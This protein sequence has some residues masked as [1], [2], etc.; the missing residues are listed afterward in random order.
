MR[1]R[2]A[3]DLG[4]WPGV[5]YLPM[6]AWSWSSLPFHLDLEYKDVIV[7]LGSTGSSLPP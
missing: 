2:K 3:R 1:K 4:T 7:G 6:L 5:G